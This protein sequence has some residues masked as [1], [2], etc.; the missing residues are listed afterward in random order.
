MRSASS[1][2]SRWAHSWVSSA[3]REPTLKLFVGFLN[4][5]QMPAQFVGFGRL[6]PEIIQLFDK[7][8]F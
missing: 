5:R 7:L 6:P 8:A 1:V 4:V 3:L 2:R